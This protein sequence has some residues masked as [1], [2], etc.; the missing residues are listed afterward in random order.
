VA[1]TQSALQAE[2]GLFDDRKVVATGEIK[3]GKLTYNSALM[4]R[5]MLGL[6]RATGEK[7]YLEQAKR[8]G[9]A[10]DWFLDEKTGA[11]RDAP[12]YSHFM[13]EADLELYRATKEEY[14]LKRAKKNVDVMYERWKLKPP[15]DLISNGAIG[16]V[17]WLMAETETEAGKAFWQ[18][19]DKAG[20]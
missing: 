8:I 5:A 6:Y 17:L 7:D 15:A 9:K 3:R 20:K 4:L 10:A 19:S 14:L 18:S 11:Y 2:D 12:R 13:I 1:W 16:R